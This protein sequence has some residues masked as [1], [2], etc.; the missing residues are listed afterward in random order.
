MPER[1]RAQERPKV[2]GATPGA[3]DQPGRPGAERVH[4]I[5]A[6]RA[7][8]IPCTSESTLRPGSAAPGGLYASH[9]DAFT[10]SSIRTRCANVAVTSK[11]A[12]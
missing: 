5:D 8:S 12:C 1:E 9:T 11:Q 7:A 2:E 3:Q 10:N 4:L 6:A